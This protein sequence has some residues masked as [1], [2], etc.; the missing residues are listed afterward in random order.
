MDGSH[1]GPRD[2]AKQCS[3]RSN[4]SAIAFGVRTRHVQLK[5]IGDRFQNSRS[6]HKVRNR[7]AEYGDENELVRGDVNGLQFRPKRACAGIREAHRI[8]VASFRILSE[9]RLAISASRQQAYAL[10]RDDAYGRNFPEAPGDGAGVRTPDPGRDYESAGD[11]LLTQPVL[12][13]EPLSRSVQ[14]APSL[15]PSGRICATSCATPKL[16]W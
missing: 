5:A 6:F 16:Q 2:A 3:I 13:L 4:F 9:D 14:N 1:H 7:G 15:N 11:F 10:R 12:R 8:D